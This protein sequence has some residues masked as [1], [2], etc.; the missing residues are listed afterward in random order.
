MWENGLLNYTY[1]NSS[2][3]LTF[4][5]THTERTPGKF[6][7]FQ[8]CTFPP[9]WNAEGPILNVAWIKLHPAKYARW[10]LQ[11]PHRAICRQ[12]SRIQLPAST[13]GHGCVLWE[14]TELLISD[15]LMLHQHK[16]WNNYRASPSTNSADQNCYISLILAV[17]KSLLHCD[18]L[19]SLSQISLLIQVEQSRLGWDQ[20]SLSHLSASWQGRECEAELKGTKQLEK[21]AQ[22]NHCSC[23]KPRAWAVTT[24]TSPSKAE[25]ASPLANA[26]SCMEAAPSS[27]WRKQH[28]PTRD[29]RANSRQHSG[30]P[31]LQQLLKGKEA[32]Q[33]KPNSPAEQIQPRGHPQTPHWHLPNSWRMHLDCAQN[34]KAQW[35]RSDSFS[36]W[37]MVSLDKHW[38]EILL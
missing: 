35:K 22:D 13:E 29:C 37:R 30:S 5:L 10:M 16:S 23:H 28:L 27:P 20:D 36:S 38:K 6:F 31:S 19:G 25:E 24:Q 15:F 8:S 2:L 7:L 1:V 3:S 34:E 11:C 14:N 12:L 17:S 33:G 32:R 9:K 26:W 4:P 21:L 18:V